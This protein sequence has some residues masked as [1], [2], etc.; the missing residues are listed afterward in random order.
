M[1]VIS[2]LLVANRGEIAVRVMKTAKALGIGTVAVYSDADAD[3]LHVQAADQAVRLGPGPV[4]ESYLRADLV[5]DA[6]RQAGADAVHPAYGFLS[7]NA[8]FADAVTAAGLIFVGPSRHAIDVMGDKARAKRAMLNAGVRCIPGYQGEDQSDDTL[9]EQ[10]QSIG[11]PLMV[12]A[13]AG[14]GGRGMRWVEESDGLRQAIKLAR[15][16]AESAFGSGDL[17]L[18]RAIVAPRHVEIQVFAD[19]HGN[20]IH[21]GERDC[22]V[23][24]RHQKVIEEAP[25]PVMTPSLR[26]QMGQAAV[27]AARAVDYRGAGTVEFLLDSDSRFYFL[28]MNTRLQVEHPVTEA[29]TGFDLVALQLKVAAGQP[30]AISQSDVAWHGHAIEVRL[31]AEDPETGFLPATGPVRLFQVPEREGLRVDAGIETGGDVSPFYDPMVAKIIVHGADREDARRKLVWALGETALFGPKTNRDF[32]I[33]ALQHRAFVEGEATTAFIAETYGDAGVVGAGATSEEMALA[34][35]ALFRHRREEARAAALDV[36]DELLDWSSEGKAQSMF[37]A[38]MIQTGRETVGESHVVQPLG[39]GR[40]RVQHR[41]AGGAVAKHV[42]QVS[43]TAA[44]AIT[45]AVDG[46]VMPAVFHATAPESLDIATARKTFTVNEHAGRGSGSATGDDDE[47]NGQVLAP[48]HGK[49]VSIDV[50]TGALVTKGQRLAVLEAMKM[51]HE[52]LAQ[53]DG[54]VAEV[55]AQAEAQVAAEDLILRIEPT[56]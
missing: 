37:M 3:A 39:Q 8:E 32:L 13:A 29:V 41:D 11:F 18:E 54:T 26:E 46:V 14:G 30:L 9:I 55:L 1:S 24:R 16:E 28:E 12:K 51:Q 22:S 50:A 33:D 17:I 31:Y 34:M 40:Y 15:S 6:A 45:Y 49:L 5:L 43:R 21:L 44:E 56:A 42:V 7:E 47:S 52:I 53:V 10:A 35:V 2:K 23:Q 48:M 36:P 27:E 19:N 38:G 4:G 25:C 20:V